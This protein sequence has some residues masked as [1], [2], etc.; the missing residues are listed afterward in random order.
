LQRIVCTRPAVR[1]A[2]ASNQS[3]CRTAMRVGA[4]GITNR[5]GALLHLVIEALEKRELTP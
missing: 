1:T 3:F 4:F 2:A 5:Q